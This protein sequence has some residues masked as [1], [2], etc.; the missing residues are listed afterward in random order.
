MQRSGT[1]EIH[2][3]QEIRLLR[4]KVDMKQNFKW[5]NLGDEINSENETPINV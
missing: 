1:A 3:Q 4:K 5:K 2:L